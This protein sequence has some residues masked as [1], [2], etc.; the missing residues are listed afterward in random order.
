MAPAYRLLARPGCVAVR[1]SASLGQRRSRC[2]ADRREPFVDARERRVG[3]GGA[4]DVAFASHALAGYRDGR[5]APRASAPAARGEIE[6]GRGLA[7]RRPRL[8]QRGRQ[9]VASESLH[10]RVRYGYCERAGVPKPIRLHD[11]RHT[12]ATLAL[13]AGIHPKVVSERP[14]AR[15]HERESRSTSTATCNPSS[16]LTPRPRSPRLFGGACGEVFG[17]D[18]PRLS[19]DV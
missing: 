7:G 19:A 15:D 11:L 18:V 9:R 2:G 12:W 16:T 13:Q 10:A 6:R 3:V 14:R 5:G 4:E 8:L 1:R 17:T